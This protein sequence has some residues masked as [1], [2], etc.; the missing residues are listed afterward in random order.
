MAKRFT[1]TEKWDDPF[2]SELS[3]CNKL[4][5]LFLLDKCN[6]AGIWDVNKRL[7]EFSVGCAVDLDEVLDVFG[8]RIEVLNGQ[9]WF[10]RKFIE[11]QYGELNE[12][13]RTHQ[14]V[15]NILKKQ[16]VS[17]GY[18][19]GIYTL[20]GTDTGTDKDKDKDKDTV[21]EHPD[22]EKKF[23]IDHCALLVS[24]DQTWV[25]NS[26]FVG[27]LKDEFILHLKGAGETEKNPAD[28]KKHFWNW[29]KKLPEEKK[30]LKLVF[31]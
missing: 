21:L 11:F 16:G 30:P 20:K 31:K 9:K 19:K 27:K 2:F 6:H 1:A 26:G 7:L 28:F 29:K 14:S 5:W 13:S 10:I 18:T 15:I 25:N 24:N 12:G 23:P 22:S 8:D 4:I 3:A 17:K